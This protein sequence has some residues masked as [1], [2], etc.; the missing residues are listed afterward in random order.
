[1]PQFSLLLQAGKGKVTATHRGEG[2]LSLME[3][4]HPGLGGSRMV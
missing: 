2:Q 4:C 1:M 3:L